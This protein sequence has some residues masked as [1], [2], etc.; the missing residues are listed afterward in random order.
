M[1]A[2]QATSLA[3]AGNRYAPGGVTSGAY[4]GGMSTHQS[5][6]PDSTSLPDLN[7]IASAAQQGPPG[8][9]SNVNMPVLLT[10][11]CPRAHPCLLVLRP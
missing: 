10:T 5:S 4:F 7:N 9:P 8:Q 11:L 6:R 2:L 1:A 3:K